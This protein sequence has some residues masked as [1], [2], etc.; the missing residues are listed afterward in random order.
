MTPAKA[1]T[2]CMEPLCPNLATH[3]GRCSSCRSEH[4]TTRRGSAR[5]RGYDS[6][7]ERRRW[8]HLEIEPWCRVCGLPGKDVDHVIPHRGARWLFDL[9]GNLQTLCH[10]HHTRKT[11][12]EATIP[13]G[14]MYPLEL[15][16]P[17]RPVRLYCGPEVGARRG[18]V[19]DGTKL[20]DERRNELLEEGL[21]GELCSELTVML[22]A[23]R[24]A[25][26]AFW[27]HVLGTEARLVLPEDEGDPA[28]WWAEYNRDH[29]AEEAMQRRAG[30]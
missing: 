10:R 2:P 20:T 5:E 6:A 14:I 17:R 1:P 15:P 28:W 12:H 4:E 24:T 13:I 25:E 26:R 16:E 9:E 19:I 3:G 7:W 8:R 21:G 27:S 23:P 29:K 18:F 30:G 22:A 11:M